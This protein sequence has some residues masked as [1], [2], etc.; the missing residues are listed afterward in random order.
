MKKQ[1]ITAAVF[2]ACLALCR[3]V[4]TERTGRG[5]T[6]TA[7]ASRCNRHTARSSGDT[8]NRRSQ[9]TRGRKGASN[10]AGTGRGS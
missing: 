4:A 1:I 3:C 2:A 10:T 8:R 7:H 6:R 9:I 5:N